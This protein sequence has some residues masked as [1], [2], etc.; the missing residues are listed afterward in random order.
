MSKLQARL[1]ISHFRVTDERIMRCLCFLG[2]KTAPGHCSK[3]KN[4]CNVCVV[5]GT[6]AGMMAV[7]MQLNFMISSQSCEM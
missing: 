4:I 3:V 2:S 5:I 7:I 6:M 1:L